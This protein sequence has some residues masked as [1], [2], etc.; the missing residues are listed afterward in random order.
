MQRFFIAC[1]SLLS[2][3]AIAIIFLVYP[4]IRA[5]HPALSGGNLPDLV[6][7]NAFYA[8][9]D[10]RWRYRL[11]PDGQRIAWLEAKRLKP[12]LWVRDLD[13]ETA[14]VFHT[15][16][17]VRWYAWSSD[18]QYLL[19]LADRDG[20]ENDKLVSIDVTR[21]GSA[22]RAYNFGVG[23][24]TFLVQVPTNSGN[25][26]LISHN[27]RDRA[28]FDLYRLNLVSGD[29]EPVGEVQERS[30]WWSFTP[31][32]E[33]YART[34]GLN[35]STWVTE[36]KSDNVWRPI[37]SGGMEDS[38]LPLAPPD[39]NGRMLAISNRNRDT[40]ALVY[41]HV[42]SKKET[43][44]VARDDVDLS[45]VAMH[46]VNNEPMMAVSNPGKQVRVFLDE[47]LQA[48]LEQLYAAEG[49]ALHF[50]SSTAD[51]SKSI[52]EVESDTQGWSKYFVDMA[53]GT[54][55]LFATPSIVKHADALSPT[56]PVFITA[57]D[58]L[59]IPAFLTRA[60]G[61]LR[62]GPMVVLIHGGPVAR[63][64]WG[65]NGLRSWM[66]N[67]GY[68]VLDVNYRGSDGYGRAF[69]EAAIGEVSR[70]M[71]SDIADARQWAVDQG[72]A[73]PEKVAVL[74]GSW[75]G[76]QTM[77]ALTENPDLYAAG[78]NINGIGDISTML[79]EVPVY[80]TGWPDW[81]RKYI[82]DPD[83]PAQLDE[84]KARSPLYNVDSVVAPTLVIQGANDVRV[85]RDQA[86]RL[87]SA[88]RAAGKDVTFELIPNAGHTFANWGWKT[89]I[90]TFR[91]IERFLAK[92]LGGRADG[93]DYAVFGAQI[94]PF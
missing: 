39:S 17:E 14:D 70:K 7:L 61:V 38:F 74:G 23:V 49:N 2:F 36:L 62:P 80:W 64:Y 86:D 10:A 46:P 3:A 55:E 6:P 65:F 31:N 91:K 5:T 27:G 69:R 15:P 63:T 21:P 72:I 13:E 53:S 44:L 35:D 66:A 94:L 42:E 92:H 24:R 9:H 57:S 75:G 81:Y 52:W 41:R 1:L 71:N 56:K 85:V 84:I 67:R 40:R 8:D 4:P 51:F 59:R 12:A 22:P 34:R 68:H 54:V 90:L 73:D 28:K 11:S 50:V 87:V 89:R 25:E 43:E 47:D 76:L 32:G 77:T 45:W 18:G 26:V 37:A 48:V 82:G 29:A 78:V 93:F 19:Y 79:Q 20:R 60:K 88:M 33:I 30:V 83:D 16:D 58:G